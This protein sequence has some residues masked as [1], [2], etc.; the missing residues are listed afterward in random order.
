[1]RSG[2]DVSASCAKCWKPVFKE[3]EAVIWKYGLAGRKEKKPENG[4]AAACEHKIIKIYRTDRY[5]AAKCMHCETPIITA[6]E[7]RVVRGSIVKPRIDVNS[8]VL[9]GR[10]K[11]IPGLEKTPEIASV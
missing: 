8:A 4:G 11:P 6:P 3:K 5:V 1:M 2:P 10:Q 9:R 7:L